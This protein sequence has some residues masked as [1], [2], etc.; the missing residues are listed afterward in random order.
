MPRLTEGAT[1]NP[2]DLTAAQLQTL[3]A[4]MEQ[5]KR[6]PARNS[7]RTAKGAS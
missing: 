2:E 1:D 6:K 7:K 4:G 3:I 5:L